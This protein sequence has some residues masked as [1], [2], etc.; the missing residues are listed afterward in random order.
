M[1]SRFTVRLLVAATLAGAGVAALPAAALAATPAPDFEA[2]FACGT[3]VR[4]ETGPSHDGSQRERALDMYRPPAVGTAVVASSGGEVHYTEPGGV[5]IEHGRGWFSQYIHMRNRIPEGSK[6]LRGQQIGT[7]S[8]V[9]TGTAHLHYEQLYDANGDGWADNGEWV[10]PTL[11]GIT[12]RLGASGQPTETTIVSQNCG[13]EDDATVQFAEINGGGREGDFRDEIVSVGYT[14]ATWAYLNRGWNASGGVYYG[15][16]SARVANGFHPP[17]TRFAD[18]DGDGR[19]EIIGI[20]GNGTAGA[21]RNR[22][23]GA[24]GGV[25]AGADSKVVALGFR[26]WEATKFADVNGD[27]RDD[28]IG[29]DSNGSVRAYRNRGWTAAGGVFDGADSKVVALGFRNFTATKF[30][31]LNGDSRD[32][33]LGIDGNGTVVAYRNRGWDAAGGVYTGSDSKT[34]AL[35]FRNHAATKFGDIDGDGRDEILGIDPS[36][37]VVAYRNRGWD[38]A[39]GVYTGSDSKMVALGFVIA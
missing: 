18:L 29:I 16:D 20:D 32:E 13:Q 3:Q 35:G 33:I 38:A 34:V 15:P 36:G 4:M 11:N 27:G 19:D 9:G 26:D 6:V 37:T 7:V 2:P 14:G 23:W 24:A 31:D 22:G 1:S 28:L 12:Y 39:G 25:Y 17:A 10:H 8:D 30:A 21:Y 5:M